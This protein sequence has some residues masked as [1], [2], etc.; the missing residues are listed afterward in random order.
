[1]HATDDWPENV[2]FG[3]HRHGDDAHAIVMPVT[4]IRSQDPEG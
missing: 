3:T 4:E 2:A 1:M